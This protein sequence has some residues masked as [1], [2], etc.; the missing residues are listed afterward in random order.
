MDRLAKF[1]W[2]LIEALCDWSVVTWHK[3]LRSCNMKGF[4]ALAVLWS[5]LSVL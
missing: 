1:C 5:V 3:Y 4:L 2:L